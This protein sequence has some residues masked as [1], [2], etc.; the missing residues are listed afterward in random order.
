MDLARS[1]PTSTCEIVAA[2]GELIATTK[3]AIL[4]ELIMVFDVSIP[5]NVGDEVRRKLPSGLR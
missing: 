2:N 1:L 4:P 3:A 5:I